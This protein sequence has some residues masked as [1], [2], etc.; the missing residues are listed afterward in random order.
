MPN[1]YF[2]QVGGNSKDINFLKSE[3]KSFDN[4]IFIPHQDVESLIQLQLCSDALFYMITKETS[5]YWCCSPMKIFEYLASGKPIVA[6][7]IGSLN[8]ILSKDVA[9]LYDPEDRDS[10]QKAL[11]KLEEGSANQELSKNAISLVRQKYT[12]VI[13][14]QQIIS[15]LKLN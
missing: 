14:A 4:F 11:L 9:L 6:S 12:W 15:F 8:E 5:T 3:F 13:R 7:N 10:L 2:V 1:W